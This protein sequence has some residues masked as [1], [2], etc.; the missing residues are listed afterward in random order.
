MRRSMTAGAA[1]A[2]LWSGGVVAQEAAERTIQVAAVGS[3]ETAPEFA[4]ISYVV[5]GEGKTSDEATRALVR[6]KDAVEQALGGFGEAKL[7]VHTG[8]MAIREV[9]A[10]DCRSV[11]EDEDT[12]R[13]STG[14]CAIEG[15]VASIDVNAKVSPVTTA[16]TLTGLAARAGATNVEL[17]GF[18]ILDEAAARRRAVAAA[19]A[20][21]KAQ[22]EAIASASG[23]RLGPLVRV[24]DSDPR[25]FGYN[26][27]VVT[28]S[29]Q[30][31]VAEPIVVNIAPA[32]VETQARLLLTFEIGR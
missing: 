29:L 20:N 26:E 30:R 28:G 17:A 6:R 2:L 27:I 13:L 5:R 19:I 22:A 10:R 25:A 21:G 15:Y 14:V 24:V 11:D 3:V 12:P 31:P 16:G 23:A 4:R 7:E 8:E 1:L 32:P 9:R 18:G